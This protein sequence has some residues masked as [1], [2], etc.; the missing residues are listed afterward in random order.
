MNIYNP[1]GG[2]NRFNNRGLERKTAPFHL[3][4]NGYRTG[5]IGK[6]LNGYTRQTAFHVPPGYDRWCAGGRVG[7]AWK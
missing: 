5:L 7:A 1:L 3:Q 6:Y 2:F 4:Q